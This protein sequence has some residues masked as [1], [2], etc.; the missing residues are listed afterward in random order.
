MPAVE[1]KKTSDLPLDLQQLVAMYEAW[2]GDTVFARV[3]AHRPEAFRAF[4]EF[5]LSLL[6]GRVESEI[7][8]LAR[9]RLAR[10]NGCEY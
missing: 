9:L 4:H 8:E 6:N 2:I 5:Y 3:I 7:K 10:L 1:L